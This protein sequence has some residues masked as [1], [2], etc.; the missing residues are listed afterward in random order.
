MVL[1]ISYFLY[2]PD[3]NW[4]PCWIFKRIKFYMLT[5]SGGYAKYPQNLPIGCKNIM[6]FQF[7]KMAATAILDFQICKISLTDSVRKAQAHHCAKSHQIRSF[8]CRGVAISHFQNGHCRHLGFWNREI[9]L[10]AIGVQ[11][12]D[13]HQFAKF[14]QNR[15]ISCEDIKIF[16]FFFKMAAVHHIGFVWGIFGPTTHSVYLGSLSLCKIWLWSMQ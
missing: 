15:S 7:F 16:Q 6:I 9:F 11:S 14:R 10:L 8:R 5:R 1:E 4:P 3:G 13:T 12:F 2:F